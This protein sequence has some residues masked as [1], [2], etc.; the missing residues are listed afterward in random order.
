MTSNENTGTPVKIELDVCGVPKLPMTLLEQKAVD[1]CNLIKAWA[2]SD[3]S[4]PF[5][6]EAHM[7]V[8][9]VLDLATLRRQGVR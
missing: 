4:T 9:L 2:E 5:P 7:G 6:Q 8:D 3:R 1:V